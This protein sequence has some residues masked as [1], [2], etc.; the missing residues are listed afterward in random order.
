MVTA[1]LLGLVQALTEFLPV[2]SSGHLRLA[3]ALAG[4]EVPDDLLFD[5]VLHVGTLVAVLFVYRA[6]VAWLLADALRALKTAARCVPTALREH[7]GARYAVLMVIATVPTGL[8]GVA[9]S[10]LVDSDAFS[11]PV[12]GALLCVNGLVLWTSKRFSDGGDDDS[13]GLR[14]GG[15]GPRE[16]LIIGIAQG[17]AVLPGISRA[18]STIV[19]ALA[20]GANRMKAAEFS[21]FLSI[22][23]ILGAVVLEFDPALLTGGPDGP[24][25]YIVGALVSAVGGVLAL[26]LLLGVVRAARLHHFAWY[27]W[28]LGVAAVVFAL[29]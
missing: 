16:A 27:C 19:C 24:T 29:A 4:F 21:F 10:G 26:R 13:G 15:I 28:I 22:P 8:I 25:P 14:V 17:I 23:A 12:V 11:V 2:S 1:A 7:E 5:I 3:H 20:L 9:L 6:R 18:G